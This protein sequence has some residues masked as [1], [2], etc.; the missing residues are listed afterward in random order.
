M[1][2]TITALQWTFAIVGAILIFLFF[3]Q[4]QQNEHTEKIIG[5]TAEHAKQN[6][7]EVIELGEV[8]ENKSVREKLSEGVKGV[9]AFVLSIFSKM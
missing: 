7:S 4:K 9:I 3:W 5:K 6:R 2:N 1:K 8:T